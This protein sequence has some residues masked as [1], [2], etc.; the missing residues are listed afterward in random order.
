M[1]KNAQTLS[2]NGIITRPSDEIKDE[3]Q[4]T[5]VQRRFVD[6]YL[7]CLNATKAAIAAGY[8]P[9][10]AYELGSRLLRR[11]DIRR[12][13]EKAEAEQQLQRAQEIIPDPWLNRRAFVKLER[14]TKARAG[15]EVTI[16]GTVISH[17]AAGIVIGS[18][19]LSKAE[20]QQD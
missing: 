18:G 17:G 9:R 12:F 13:I 8:S 3:A 11:P 6:E 16:R 1:T 20:K 5:L 2:K 4:L 19:V 14:S 7:L 10:S 15:D